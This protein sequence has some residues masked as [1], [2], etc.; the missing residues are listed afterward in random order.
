M[1]KEFY[2]MRLT[3][4]KNVMYNIY[5]RDNSN[6]QKFTYI[7]DI[8][9]MSD[10]EYHNLKKQYGAVVTQFDSYFEDPADADR[11]VDYLNETYI[12]PLKLRGLA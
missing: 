7:P 11:L 2:S 5:V 8:L 6:F 1:I 3:R 12:I 9:E 4:G 10:Q